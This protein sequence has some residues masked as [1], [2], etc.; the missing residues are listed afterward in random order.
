M[1]ESKVR[2]LKWN[3][4]K[5][6]GSVLHFSEHYVLKTESDWLVWSVEQGTEASSVWEK[7]LKPGLNG[8]KLVKNR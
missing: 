2:G 4:K 7:G 1:N 3:L 6:S 8:R 5:I